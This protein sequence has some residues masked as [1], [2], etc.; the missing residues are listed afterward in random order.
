MGLE[1]INLNEIKLLETGL[2]IRGS[3]VM[4]FC[5]S[6]RIWSLEQLFIYIKKNGA[7]SKLTQSNEEI[8]GVVRLLKYKYLGEPLNID[9]ILSIELKYGEKKTFNYYLKFY[10]LFFLRL[11]FSFEEMKSLLHF[12]KDEFKRDVSIAQ[13]ILYF[14]RKIILLGESLGTNSKSLVFKNK[15]L[16]LANYIKKNSFEDIT[17]FS[18]N[19]EIFELDLLLE[20][21]KYLSLKKKEIENAI[22]ELES[23][24]SSKVSSNNNLLNDE[25]KKMVKKFDNKDN[26]A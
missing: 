16:L 2:I 6:R 21:Y 22:V 9:H 23:L 7:D 4:N 13:L 17:F 10:A 19:F 8:M 11:G 5:L 15:L 12:F 20:R 18:N 1:D 25:V 3:V 24:I 14:E 26:N